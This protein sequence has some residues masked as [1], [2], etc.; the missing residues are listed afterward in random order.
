[1]HHEMEQIE[2]ILAMAVEK[3]VTSHPQAQFAGAIGTALLKGF[4]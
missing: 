3:E 1:M 2:K 4:K